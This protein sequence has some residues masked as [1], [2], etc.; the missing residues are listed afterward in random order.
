MFSWVLIINVLWE[1]PMRVILTLLVCCCATQAQAT[2]LVYDG[3][4]YNSGD[5]LAPTNDTVGSPNPGLL[6][7]AYGVNWRYAGAGGA[8]NKAPGIASTGLI[9]AGLQA[10]VGNSVT[11][12][13]TQIGSARNSFANQTSGTV[14]WSALLR[15]N[16]VNTLTTGTNGMMLG[17][18]NNA[19]GPGPLPTV[20][21]AVLRIKADASDPTRY[22]IGT[23]MNSGTGTGTGGATNVQFESTSR[24]ESISAAVFV[25]GAYTFVAGATN[26]IAQMWINPDA[27]T[28][29][30]GSSPAATL[31]SAPGPAIADS[32]TQ[33][34]S[35]NL[36]NVNT[37][38]APDVQFDELR[39]GTTWA[40]VTPAAVVVPEPA[41]F[42]FLLVSCGLVAARRLVV[43]PFVRQALTRLN[44]HP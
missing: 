33:I 8:S 20:V 15:V 42:L 3:F 22:F 16:D 19:T 24:V 32:S 40:D 11:F 44:E 2:L 36:R 39:V 25:V 43:K 37:V 6:N 41:A 10:G 21:G 7:T 27:S 26:D 14:Y 23:G 9:Y 12:N 38:G 29:G 1:G 30:A 31:T 4:E 34:Q 13:S 5:L 18:L 35:F 28:F 17:G